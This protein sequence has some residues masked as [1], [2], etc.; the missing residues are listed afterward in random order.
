VVRHNGL[1]LVRIR[2]EINLL[3]LTDL[4]IVTQIR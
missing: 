4:F 3:L 1:I 2:Q